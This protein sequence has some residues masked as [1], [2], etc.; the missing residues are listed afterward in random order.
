M[1]DPEG[2]GVVQR[3]R[4]LDGGLHSKTEATPHSELW[5][6]PTGF[7]CNTYNKGRM[8]FRECELGGFPGC[9]IYAAWGSGQIRVWR[10]TYR[11]S[12]AAN[13]R[14]GG[15]NS[16]I[17]DVDVEVD[18]IRDEW[19]ATRGIRLEG[20]D[21]ITVENCRV[22]ISADSPNSHGI[23]IQKNA[24]D[25]VVRDT[26]VR[27]DTPCFN[28]GIY[29]APPAGPVSVYDTEVEMNT[30]GGAGLLIKGEGTDDERAVFADVKVTGDARDKWNRSG[31]YNTRNNVEFRGVIVDQRGSERRN[32]LENFGDDCT[33]YK[34]SLYAHNYPFADTARG[35]WVEDSYFGSVGGRAGIRL[36]DTSSDV[37]LKRN[38]VLNGIQDEGCDGVKSIGNRVA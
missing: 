4:A 34:C 15:T 18:E 25:V 19:V 7:L 37:V 6:G 20:A 28:H 5:R 29:V 26:T 13:V 21:G 8:T 30:P 17:Y 24:R 3:F 32:G 16:Q 33:V 9:G 23:S 27:M 31:I 2:T 11:N 36:T 38:T 12:N 22:H 10:G 14:V 35:T 1:T